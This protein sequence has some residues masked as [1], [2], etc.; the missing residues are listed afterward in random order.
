MCVNKKNNEKVAAVCDAM[1]KKAP[2]KTAEISTVLD[3]WM[4]SEWI[5]C[6]N[7]WFQLFTLI[8]TIVRYLIQ[9]AKP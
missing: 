4:K 9:Q 5:F 6:A 3:D 1:L 8:K 7:N 2:V